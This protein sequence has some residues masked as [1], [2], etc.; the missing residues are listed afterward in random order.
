MAFTYWNTERAL[1]A[2]TDQIIDAEITGLSEQYRT[3]GLRGLYEAVNAR[4]RGGPA[5]CI[6][7]DGLHRI[8]AGKL[9]SWP[10]I[11]ATPDNFVEF[12][13]ERRVNGQIEIRRARGRLIALADN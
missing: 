1:D 11:A 4:P 8:R 3:L 2:Q 13:Y 5:L 7:S 6:L 12:D 9:D 10:Q